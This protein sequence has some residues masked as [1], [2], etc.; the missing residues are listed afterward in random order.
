MKIISKP[1]GAYQTNCYIVQIDSKELIIDP[2]IDAYE[3]VC[4]QVTHPKAILNTH[5]HFDHVWSN[6]ALQKHFGIPIY[7]PQDDAFMIKQDPFGQGTPSSDV[8]YEVKGDE[9]VLIDGIKVQFYHMPGHTPGCSIIQI[10]DVI[11]S[12][13]FVFQNS[14]GRVD[15]P[16]SDPQKMKESIKKF[17]QFE[18]DLDIYPGHGASTSV[19]K[20]Q[21]TLPMW[22]GHI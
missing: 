1:C 7:A 14:I 13:D 6:K 15:F 4:S 10:E 11:F 16:Y 9:E 20:E 21:R 5:G 8:D 3:W 18:Q 19:K 12:G 22:L 17:L 2:G